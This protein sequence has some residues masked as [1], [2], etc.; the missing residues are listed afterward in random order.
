MMLSRETLE[1]L[2]ITGEF[3]Y[4][5]VASRIWLHDIVLQLYSVKSFVEMTQ[6]LLRQGED[7][8][9]LSERVSQ[10]P[11]E[12]YFGQQRARGGRSEN[13]T[14]DLTIKN[15]AALRI[16][17]SQALD[18]VRGNCSRKRRLYDDLP[19]SIDSAP[20]PKRKRSTCTNWEL[21]YYYYTKEL[22]IFLWEFTIDII[23]IFA[24]TLLK[25]TGCY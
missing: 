9:I 19:P 2:Q 16:Q 22:N 4:I 23:K 5:I 20:L 18:P 1:G 11:L 21:C 14:M 6:Y 15:A 13:P 25:I 3:A 12:N 8:F 7:L 24:T 10:D 17:K